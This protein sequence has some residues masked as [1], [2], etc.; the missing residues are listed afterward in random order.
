MI[1]KVKQRIDKYK[2]ILKIREGLSI[3]TLEQLI[4]INDEVKK[5]IAEKTKKGGLRK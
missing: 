2:F 5:A 1:L 4:L 3:A